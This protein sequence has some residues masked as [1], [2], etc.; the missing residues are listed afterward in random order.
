MSPPLGMAAQKV[1]SKNLA[2]LLDV[3]EDLLVLDVRPFLQFNKG[4]IRS[5]MNLP[6][7]PLMLRR[8]RNGK[9]ITEYVS[10]D[11]RDRLLAARMVVLYDGQTADISCL[12]PCSPL[13]T[14][15]SA[16]GPNNFTLFFLSGII[17]VLCSSN[18]FK[19]QKVCLSLSLSLS[20]SKIMFMK[21]EEK[22]TAA[23]LRKMNVSGY[24]LNNSSSIKSS[25]KMKK[26]WWNPKEMARKMQN[27]DL[28]KCVRC[29]KLWRLA[30]RQRL[31]GF[32]FFF[33]YQWEVWYE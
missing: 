2:D 23:H 33:S 17:C 13:S 14:I 29:H 28:L 20:L 12:P 21:I 16:L 3:L 15:A 19:L 8:L 10:V 31:W 6:C 26:R 24:T 9:G 1:S 25:L 4:H 5:A 30:F 7:S 32:F 18:L 11:M 27:W 22:K